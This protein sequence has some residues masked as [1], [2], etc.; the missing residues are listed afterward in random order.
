MHNIHSTNWFA[1][2]LTA[3]G[4]CLILSLNRLLHWRKKTKN[5]TIF[6]SW[7]VIKARDLNFIIWLKRTHYKKLHTFD[8]DLDFD[9]GFCS[10]LSTFV[11]FC[12]L[13]C[14]MLN[15]ISKHLLG[16]HRACLCESAKLYKEQNKAWIALLNFNSLNE[17]DVQTIESLFFLL[18]MIWMFFFPL[19]V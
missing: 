11:L 3:G 18:I 14:S 10:E 8:L 17:N 12:L 16:A 9:S 15:M 5:N 6:N 1:F 4:I 19:S 2:T 7:L 13:C